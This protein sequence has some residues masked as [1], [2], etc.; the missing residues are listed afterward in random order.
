MTDEFLMER[1]R[2]GDAAMFEALVERYEKPLYGFI[3]RIVGDRREAEDLFQECFLRIHQKRDSYRA[4]APFRPWL[5]RI[6]LN[7]CR[8]A[9]RRRARRHLPLDVEIT[10]PAPGPEDRARQSVVADRIRGAVDAL[11][12]KQREVFVLHQYQGLPY[13]EIAEVVGIP[14]GTVKSRMHYAVNA[15]ADALRDL[16]VERV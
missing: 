14:L 2:E 9:L 8:D 6:C 12:D 11:P 10:D 4:G 1:V 16:E 7:L 3:V 13:P 5:Y 15:L